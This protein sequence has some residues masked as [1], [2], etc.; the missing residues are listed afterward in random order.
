MRKLWLLFGLMSCCF[1]AEEEPKVFF[2]HLPKAGGITL[3]SMIEDHYMQEA[4]GKKMLLFPNT[5]SEKVEH[6]FKR[7]AFVHGHLLYSEVKEMASSFKKIALMRDPIERVIS[8][9]HYIMERIPPEER[10]CVLQEHFLPLKGEPIE[11]ASN[12][13]C[14]FFSQLDPRDPAISIEQHLA[15]AKQ[16]LDGFDFVGITEQ[17]E[18]SVDVFYKQMGWE[19]PKWMP[20]HNITPRQEV[21]AAGVREAIA[22]RNKADIELYEYAKKRFEAL[23]AEVHPISAQSDLLWASEIDYS[24][25]QPLD[26]WGWCPR[27]T[28]P[29]G[30]FRWLCSPEEGHIFFPLA[31]DA[32]YI[33]KLSLYLPAKLLK[34]LHVTIN[35]HRL[36]WE[37]KQKTALEQ[38]RWVEIEGRVPR[39]WIKKGEKTDL[40]ISI[41]D[42]KRK[43]QE[44][45]YRGRCGANWIRFFSSAS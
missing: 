29:E 43:P 33:V 18:E 5:P 20:M 28:L 1:A 30:I 45:S 8:E 3:R 2:L 9:Q 35:G 32:D 25:N 34:Q 22:E 36:H 7:R 13:A 15:S 11:T 31:S 10:A 16:T 42:P 27:E 37:A 38:E 26:G 12:I 17:M 39:R 41:K 24:F 6:A 14:L 40:E 4:T 21:V 19:V 44:D 23:K